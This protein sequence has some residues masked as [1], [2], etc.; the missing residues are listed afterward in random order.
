GGIVFVGVNGQG[1]R[2]FP[3]IWSNV[4]PRFGFAWQALSKTIV[5]GGFGLFYAGAPTVAGGVIGNFGYRSDTPF[6]GSQ[7]GLT[8]Y[9]YLSNP[10]P[11]GLV[12]S[13]GASQ[14]LLTAIGTAIQEP[15]ASATV[16]YTEN[17]S[18]DIQREL[19][20]SILVDVA[21]VGNH[22]VNLI[23]G[24][25]G[26]VNLNQ[27]T[28]QQL[29]LGS[30]LLAPVKNPFYGL[31]ASGALSTPAIPYYYLLR[32][33]PQFTS[34]GLL[35]PQGGDSSY[36]AVQIKV[37]KRYNSGLNFMLAYTGGKLIDDNSIIENAG[38]NAARQNIYDRR[39]DRSVSAND[40]SRRLVLS[41]V[42]Q[43]PV[44]RGRKLGAGWNPFVDAVLGGWQVNGLLAL[45]TGFPLGITTQ[46]T[47]NAG[48][49]S[50]RP[51]NNGHSA[52][53]S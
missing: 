30:A 48:N 44:G 8:P 7:D 21:Y 51:N 23:E 4:A 14:G 32:Q 34:V 35:Y 22:A 16:P 2:Q 5:R 38:R 3:T 42:Y 11:N 6:I 24:A 29:T 47:S 9:S 49:E 31:I 41:S 15:L 12:P 17:W 26:N 52:D 53:L 37:E 43:L 33:Y 28:P 39:G 40:I 46:N 10:F 20:G 25:E 36:N 27:L 13:T 1:P 18:L 19:P 50:L 45:Q